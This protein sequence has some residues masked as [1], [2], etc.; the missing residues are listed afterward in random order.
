VCA[1]INLSAK[2]Y[3][4][5]LPVATSTQL[6]FGRSANVTRQD[7]NLT[8]KI[9]QSRSKLCYDHLNEKDKMEEEKLNTTF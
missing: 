5:P 4:D 6:R 9:N 2:R 1:E 3:P 8:S 7:S